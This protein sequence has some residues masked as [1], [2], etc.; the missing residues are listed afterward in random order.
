LIDDCCRGDWSRSRPAFDSNC[1][2]LS[3][4]SLNDDFGCPSTDRSTSLTD[5]IA[6]LLLLH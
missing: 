1:S 2:W 4:C 3:V 6:H 5:W